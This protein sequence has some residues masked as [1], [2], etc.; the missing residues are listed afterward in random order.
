MNFFPTKP[1][2]LVLARGYVQKK[3]K[4]IR[5]LF[6]FTTENASVQ[7]VGTTA[8][9]AVAPPLPPC[10][11]LSIVQLALLGRDVERAR[12][13]YHRRTTHTHARAHRRYHT[14]LIFFFRTTHNTTALSPYTLLAYYRTRNSSRIALCTVTESASHWGT[15]SSRSGR[16]A[17][18]S[19]ERRLVQVNRVCSTQQH[20]SPFCAYRY[21]F[22]H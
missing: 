12:A 2:E 4:K 14:K 7:S 5:L 21:I 1:D 9:A 11:E 22:F 10:R 18:F 3:K 13:T 17:R 19:A 16:A 20:Y 6:F 8:S 15:T